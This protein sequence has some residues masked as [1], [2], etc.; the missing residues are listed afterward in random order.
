MAADH[1]F[2]SQDTDLKLALVEAYL[3]A[4]TTALRR[5][6]PELWFFDAFAGTGE[7]TV[8]VA[9]RGGDLFD[10]PEPERVCE[11]R[12]GSATIA[13]EVTPPFNRI[14]FVEKRPRSIAALRVLRAQHPHRQI[15]VI[16]GDAK[17]RNYRGHWPR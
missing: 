16:A 8:R 7:R 1:E 13:I 15:E 5:F 6:F 14:V 17:P 3:K 11:R 10:E 4:F 2:G 9:A 12:R